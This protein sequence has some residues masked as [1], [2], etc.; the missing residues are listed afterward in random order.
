MVTANNAGTTVSGVLQKSLLVVVGLGAVYFL[1]TNALP[2]LTWSEGPSTDYYL[3]YRVPLLTHITG[4]LIAVVAG[5]WQVWTGLN[6]AA[7]GVHP[8]TGRLYVTGVLVGA[9][10]AFVLAFSSHLY[11][12]AWA[13]A[14]VCLALA[15]L[16]TTAMALYCI[17]RRN[18]RLHKQWMIRSYIVT[19]AFVTFRIMT[20]V[21][22]YDAWWGIS[23][24]ELANA[25]IWPVWVLP[26]LAYEIYLQSRNV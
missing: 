11:G 19:F 4:G 3:P 20:D 17:K 12:V 18:L 15:W 13:V 26:L 21:V 24:R 23:A 1:Y 25:A 6:G 5:L 2:Y 22:P 9:G 8:W 10:G 7:M 16:S 14:L